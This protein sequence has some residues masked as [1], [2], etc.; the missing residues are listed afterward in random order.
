MAIPR[1]IAALLEEEHKARPFSGRLLQLGRQEIYFTAADLKRQLK[2]YSCNPTYESD[3]ISSQDRPLSDR[4]F[5]GAHGFAVVESLDASD[6]ARADI[7][8]ELNLDS[9]PAKWHKQYD[10]VFDRGTMEQVFHIPNVLKSIFYLLKRKMAGSSTTIRIQRRRPWILF[11]LSLSTLGVLRCE[12][13]R[14][15]CLPPARLRRKTAADPSD[16]V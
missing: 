15:W 4:E 8:H 16:V 1:G 7:V 13:I 3:S 2:K 14:S 9:L 5:F 11:D 6:F 12:R 10:C